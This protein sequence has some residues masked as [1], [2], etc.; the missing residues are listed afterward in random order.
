MKKLIEWAGVI[1]CILAMFMLSEHIMLWGFIV[2]II[3]Q[4][5]WGIFA[6]C[7]RAW[8]LLSLEV[9]LF[10]ISLNGVLNA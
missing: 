1:T 3:S 10:F 6:Y 9:G 4:I 7:N 8:G 2:N 5:L